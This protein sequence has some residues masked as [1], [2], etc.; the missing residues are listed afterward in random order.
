MTIKDFHVLFE[1]NS[2]AN[3]R[4]IQALDSLSE[5]QLYMDLK[6]SFGSIHGTLV[7]LC[8]A[9]DIWLQRLNGANPGIFMKNENFPTYSSVKTKWKN[10][11]EGWQNYLVTLTDQELT[12][13][14]IFN[15]QRG[16][17][18]TQKVWQSLQHLV[19]HSTYHRG[20][21]TTMIRQSGGTPIGTDLIVF[22]RQQK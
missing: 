4:T 12:R 8:G 13:T 5:E 3:A 1:F 14:L 9:E 10:V 19:N 7:H 20:Q 11:E 22:Y 16:D 6:N 17:E 2:W 15:I 18:V 21:I